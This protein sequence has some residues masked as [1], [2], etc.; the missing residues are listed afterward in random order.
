LT[1][2]SRSRSAAEVA[3]YLRDFIDGTG[4]EWDWDD[5]TSI[6]I[7]EPEL[8]AIRGEAELIALPIRNEAGFTELRALLTRVEKIA[9]APT[10]N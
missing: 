6:P 4:G 5:F 3:K 7:K 1:W 8:E 9:A 10:S 2:G